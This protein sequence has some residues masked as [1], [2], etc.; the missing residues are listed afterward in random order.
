MAAGM[1]AEKDSYGMSMDN[2]RPADSICTYDAQ[3]K[4]RRLIQAQRWT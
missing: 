1:M 3:T 4:R 2:T